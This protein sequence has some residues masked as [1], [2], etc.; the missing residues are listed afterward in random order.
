LLRFGDA[1]YYTVGGVAF[2]L[3]KSHPNVS[4]FHIYNIGGSLVPSSDGFGT[5]GTQDAS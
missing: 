1:I 2:G 3:N 5:G 4:S